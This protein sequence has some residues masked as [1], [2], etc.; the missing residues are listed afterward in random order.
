MLAFL[1]N[2]VY[3][4]HHDKSEAFIINLLKIINKT[5]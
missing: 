5:R 2:A 1:P 4:K 3:R